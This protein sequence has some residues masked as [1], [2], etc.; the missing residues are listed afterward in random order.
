MAL[1]HPYG[2]NVRFGEGTVEGRIAQDERGD[3][4]FGYDPV[5][6]LP[7]GRRMAEL[8]RKEKNEFSHRARALADLGWAL[9]ALHAALDKTVEQ[10]AAA[11]ET[12][13]GDDES[14][15]AG[16]SNGHAGPA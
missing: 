10:R 8:S 14:T 11:K 5:F 15:N 13:S 1:T 16:A 6:E 12:G 4:G 2:P 3:L 9:D 7:D